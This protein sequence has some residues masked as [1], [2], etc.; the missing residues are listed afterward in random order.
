MRVS[1]IQ[2]EIEDG[3]PEQNL[4]HALAALKSSAAADIYLLPELFTSGYAHRTW[5]AAADQHTPGALNQL[6]DFCKDR[7]CSVL[8]GM[9]SRHHDGR[10]VNRLWWIDADS[11]AHYDKAHLIAAFREPELLLRG[12]TPL[13]V[14]HAGA[15]LHASVCFDLR[16][17]EFYRA[18][19][20]DGAEAFLIISEWPAVRMQALRTLALARAIE[21]QAWVVL[22]NR[23]GI[24]KDGTEFSGGSMIIDPEGNVVASLGAEVGTCSAELDFQRVRTLRDK[25]PVL[26]MSRRAW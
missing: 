9:V 22:C 7:G 6:Q 8:A 4:Q 15:C 18:A 14:D 10:L 1:A 12:E 25:F 17:P 5:E 2:M 19:A 11:T 13:I 16:F 20:L 21:N 26:S 3:A 23:T 24:G